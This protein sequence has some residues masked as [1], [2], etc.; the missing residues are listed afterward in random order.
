METDKNEVL[1]VEGAGYIEPKYESR[2]VAL[3][4]NEKAEIRSD[5]PTAENESLN[6]VCSFAAS[7]RLPVRSGDLENGYFIGE[8]L[9]RLLILCQPR[10]GIPDPDIN[11]TPK[12]DTHLC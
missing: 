1:R 11:M 4:N 3:G 5:S 6:I 8:K 12:A 7:R 10:G 9:T 2:L